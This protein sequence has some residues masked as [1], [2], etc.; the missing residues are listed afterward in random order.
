MWW[1]ASIVRADAMEYSLESG[2]GNLWIDLEGLG[3]KG[4][5][6]MATAG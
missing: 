2:N 1:E 4:L 5:P 3:L 6:T